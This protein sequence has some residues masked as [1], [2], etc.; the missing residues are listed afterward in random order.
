MPRREEVEMEPVV[1]SYIA[2]I[3]HDPDDE[4]LFVNFNS[5]A[6]WSYGGV[7]AETYDQMRTSTSIGSFFHENIKNQYPAR[8]E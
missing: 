2:E 7:T 8:R 1:S 3:G 5:G 6:E 4:R